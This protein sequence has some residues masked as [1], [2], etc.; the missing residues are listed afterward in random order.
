M[1]QKQAVEISR[2]TAAFTVTIPGQPA[3]AGGGRGG[4]GG[5]RGGAGAAGRGR[6]APARTPRRS[7]RH[8]RLPRRRRRASS[9]P[10]ATSSGMDQPYSR[11]ADALLDYQVPGRRTTR[12]RGPTT[13]PGWTFPE[14]F[15]VQAVRVTDVKVLDVPMELGQGRGQGAERR[16]RR[17]QRLRDQSQ[18]RQRADHAALQAE[19]RRH[20]GGGGAVRI[21]RHEVQPRHASSSRACR[22][23]ISTRPP[24]SSG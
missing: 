10:A 23:R 21:R 2:A 1:L 9:R 4:R 6:C 5:G 3:P 24:P 11:I 15:A 22:R 8:R 17:R 12:R 14:A 19:G 16:Q 20:P 7:R 13:T 18:R